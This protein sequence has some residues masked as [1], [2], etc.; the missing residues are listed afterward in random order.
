VDEAALAHD[1]QEVG[2]E[3][4]H[5]SFPENLRPFGLAVACTVARV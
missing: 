5:F 2:F 3:G 1:A 4:E